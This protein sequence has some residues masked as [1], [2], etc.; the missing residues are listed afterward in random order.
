MDYDLYQQRDKEKSIFLKR[1]AV[2]LLWF[3]VTLFCVDLS[4]AQ[5][6]SVTISHIDFKGNAKTK[7]S[8]LLKNI[9]S[10]IY[11]PLDSVQLQED[12]QRLIRIPAI[13]NAKYAIEYNEENTSAKVVFSVEENFSI[14][15]NF[16]IYTTND[17]EIAYG[18]SVTDVNFLGSNVML[19][20]FYLRDIFDSYGVS[21]RAP[22]LFSRK[23]GLAVSYNNYN[24]KEP[25]FFNTGT[26]N[27]KYS[28]EAVEVVGLYR[29]NF[30]N[31]FELGVNKFREEYLYL[32]ESG[33][34]APPSYA[35]DVVE[36]K[37]LF[38]GLYDFNNTKYFYHHVSGFRLLYNLQYVINQTHDSPD[39]II[40][41]ADALYYKEV[42]KR[43][44]WATRIRA[45][46]SSNNKSPF[47][48]FSLDNNVNI[49]GVGNVVD[50]GT[51]SV[52]MN[53]EYRYDLFKYKSVVFQT[54]A[55]VD[56][57][58]WRSPGGEFEELVKFEKAKYFSGLGFR[59][60]HQ[61]IYN[62]VFRLDYGFSLNDSTR[63][64]VIGV[65]Q[66]F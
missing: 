60:I 35:T 32:P 38:K 57:G 11:S 23:L 55:F 39:F 44:N 18:L 20:G 8:I 19:S 21:L 3:C 65:G 61:K 37:L 2:L 10:C 34:V 25:V 15:P 6:T 46:L 41:W 42:G 56:I 30:K 33:D 13:V 28:N 4:F 31:R 12:V 48:P 7:E 1:N 62:A 17:E 16:S 49:R 24:Y 43:G 50:R 45:G 5:D 22:T 47:A 63:G 54:N 58:A 40:N 9:K 29:M 51:G 52:V 59:I 14:V 27:Y 64:F 26:V 36:D 66:Y 53:T